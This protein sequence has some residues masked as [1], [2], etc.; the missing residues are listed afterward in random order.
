[1]T[2]QELLR[3]DYREEENREVIKRA[4]C[5]IKPL[6]KY[7]ECDEIP[8]EKL[9]KTVEVLIR[10]YEVMVNSITPTIIENE[11]FWYTARV[12]KTDD[13][14]YLGCCYGCCI[15]ELMAKLVIKLY[16]DI[17]KLKIPER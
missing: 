6:A 15:Y 17:K 1:M 8:L 10:K 14:K 7:S 2:T 9:E 11:M 3:L 5:K 12:T 16:S 4:L 13:L